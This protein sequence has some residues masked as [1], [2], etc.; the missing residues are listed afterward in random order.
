MNTRAM[1]ETGVPWIGA[2]PAGWDVVPLQRL[3]DPR[4]QITYGIVLPGENVSDG[5]FIIR[6]GDCTKERLTPENLHKTTRAIADQYARSRMRAGDLVIAIRGTVGAV[7]ILPEALDGANLTQDTARIAPQRDV[8]VGWLLRALQSS[9]MQTEIEAR[10]VGATI[11]GLNLRDLRR[12]RVPRPTEREQQRIAAFLDARTTTI[13]AAIAE[14]QRTLDLLAKRRQ[15]L[16]SHAVTRGLDPGVPVCDSGVATI[17]SIP[18]HWRRV[19]LKHTIAAIEQ[20]WSPQCESRPADG[21]EWGVLKVG[22]VNGEVFDPGEN[23]ALPVGLEVPTAYQVHDGDLLMSRANTRSLVGSVAIAKPGPLRLLLCDKLFR[24]RLRTALVPEYA[25]YAL[26]AAF[27]RAHIE[28]CASGASA[29]MVNIT[30]EVVRELIIP[31]P[32]LDEQ[33]AI[34]VHLRERTAVIDEATRTADRA[35]ELLR[36]Y[37]Q[38]LITAAVTG[39]VPPEAMTP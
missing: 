29:S 5:V 37:R 1:K 6:S 12:L 24:I 23:K 9:P 34:V 2:I 39:R 13:D 7:A 17:G 16:L 27:A 33:R 14:H 21:D 38:S 32:P 35:I 8:H 20:G 25:N 18:S 26:R 36:E 4:R 30:H 11:R 15:S 31:L 22:C 19:P 28:A 3:V 10:T